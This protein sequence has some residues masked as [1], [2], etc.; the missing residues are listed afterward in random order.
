MRS[1][2][3]WPSVVVRRGSQIFLFT[4]AVP[5]P[6]R[7][8]PRSQLRAFGPSLLP[9][10][11]FGLA[12]LE[13]ST[14]TR[15]WYWFWNRGEIL[16]SEIRPLSKSKFL[17]ENFYAEFDFFCWKFFAPE[18]IYI[19][20]CFFLASAPQGKIFGDIIPWFTYNFNWVW[21]QAAQRRV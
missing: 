17:G 19:C 8:A 5:I 1:C 16:M 6:E 2:H 7:F 3:F 15:V 21:P 10:S 11:A 20:L 18:Y 14:C 4:F 13:T 12:S 9:G